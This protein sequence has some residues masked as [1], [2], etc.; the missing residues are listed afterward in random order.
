MNATWLDVKQTNVLPTVVTRGWHRIQERIRH[1]AVR[2]VLASAIAKT[3]PAAPA[4]AS[5]PEVD[6]LRRDGILT[7]R[8]FVTP[9]HIAEL[10]QQLESCP[11][12]DPYRPELGEFPASAIPPQTHVAHIAKATCMTS[13]HRLALDERLLTLVSGYFGCRP[14]LDSILA[15]WSV[16]GHDGPE[17]AQ[18][19]H[20]DNDSIRFL[21]FFLYCTDVGPESGPH[22]FV[23]GSQREP[24]LL[25]RRRLTD[26]E[27]EQAFGSERILTLTGAAG[28][29]FIEDTYGVHKG[30]LPTSGR[31]LLIQVRY[32]VTHTIFRSPE[33]VEPPSFYRP[34]ASTS[35]IYAP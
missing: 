32:S 15:W 4:S 14:Y 17:E 5:G 21:K 18:N 25:A 11:C 10:R 7:F 29:A 1:P 33:L 2:N 34:D 6:A 9:A 8:Q 3:R 24:A 20:R 31:R 26:A 35:L 22:V 13:L 27:V 16:P 30:Q 19:F 12:N 23:K 28:D